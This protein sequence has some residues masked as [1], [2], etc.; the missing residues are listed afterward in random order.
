MTPAM[1]TQCGA[2]V[3][4]DPKQEAAICAYCGTPF[5]ISKG[6]SNY[7]VQTATVQHVDSINIVKTG[8]VESALNFADKQIARKAEEKK[9]IENEAR[10]QRE[11]TNAFL[12]KYWWALAAFAGVLILI[13]TIGALNE[14]KVSAGKIRVNLSLSELVGENYE[15]VVFDL[16][17]AGFTNVET[18]V[19]DD[20][21]TGWL[22]KDGEVEEV[23]IDGTT[24]FSSNSEF[25]AGVKIVVAYHTFPEQIVAASTEDQQLVT[26]NNPTETAANAP[27]TQTTT[28]TSEATTAATTKPSTA[29]ATAKDTTAATT[30][31]TTAATTAKV[32]TAATTASPTTAANTATA[33]QTNSL[34]K[35]KS[36]LA[37]SAF[38]HDDLV[39]QLEYEK[40]TH[41]QAVY[42]ADNC[43]AN[44][45]EQAAKKAK[46]YLDYSAFSRDGLVEQL[47]YDKFTYE[48]A[49]YGTDNSGA[50]WSEQAAKKAKSY[51]D[52]S[53]FSR[54][55]LVEQLV[56][57][58]FTY[59]QAVYG[60]DN[61]GA[62]W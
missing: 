52:Y 6:I 54:D 49:V 44:W 56:Y 20:L 47:V 12:K 31:T 16:K 40:F 25:E 38:S 58:K 8:A 60:V 50:N 17:K 30:Q 2:S 51:L 32:T 18:E 9:R 35:A 59:E 4:V 36:Y 57:D 27:S 10:L 46:S 13:I 11:K 1:C 45:S 15:D 55:G 39:E 3:Q 5:I 21:V 61:C 28:T 41:E 29:A 19:L 22:T 42:G 24:S 37:Y 23:K 14:S 43:G 53:A 34:S 48:Q 33:G 62:I 26:E 7:T